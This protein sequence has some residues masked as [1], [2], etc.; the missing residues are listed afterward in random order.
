MK[1]QRLKVLFVCSG[2]SKRGISPIIANQGESL[3]LRGVDV[4]YFTIQGKGVLGY[5]R[6]VLPLR[7]QLRQQRYDII[8]AHY[9]L[10]ALVATLA[11]GRPL[12]VSLMGSDIRLGP[13]FQYAV[14]LSAR[15][16]WREVIVKSIDM[17]DNLGARC[18]TIIPNGIDTAHLRPSETRAC[19]SELGWDLHR[20]H[21]LF[22]A[23][24]GRQVK[25][26]PLFQK[27]VQSLPEH[28]AI[29]YH[30]LEDVPH[31]AIPTYMNA[32]D[33]VV[34][35]SL[36]EGSP[37]VIKEAMACNCPVVATEVGD[38][39][40]LFGDEPGHY[41]TGFEPADVAEKIRLA[42]DFSGRHGRTRG[43]ERIKKLG[44]DAET[45]AWRIVEVYERALK[46]R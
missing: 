13:I 12:V 43:R 14:R 31:A 44:L 32:A 7:R 8:H 45:V 38:V 17:R 15:L 36:W 2:N 1:D 26:F 42:L 25:N 30:A 16:F 28:L 37:N 18:C 21:L 29:E 40:W 6:N 22:A 19:Q 23:N 24:P 27:A 5:L 34:L 4:D 35:T 10:S 46:Q 33:V 3:S 20:K 9:S 41:L 11:G 39:A